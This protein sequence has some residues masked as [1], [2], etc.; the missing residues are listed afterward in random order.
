MRKRYLIVVESDTFMPGASAAD[1]QAAL[2]D[3]KSNAS[4]DEL[5]DGAIPESIDIKVI[6]VLPDPMTAILGTLRDPHGT[7]TA[8]RQVF[9]LVALRHSIDIKALEMRPSINSK[10][11]TDS[12]LPFSAQ[13]KRSSTR[14][15]RY[16]TLRPGCMGAAHLGGNSWSGMEIK[17]TPKRAAPCSLGGDARRPSP[18]TLASRVRSTDCR[19]SGASPPDTQASAKLPGPY[20]PRPPRSHG[21]FNESGP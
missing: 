13:P 15:V 9:G 17:A 5:L 7:I 10:R 11:W 6:E 3:E 16:G 18:P 21:G 12:T 4:L 2:M 8:I 20:L 19:T 14:D 1:A